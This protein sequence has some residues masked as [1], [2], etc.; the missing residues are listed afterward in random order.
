MLQSGLW[1][2]SSGQSWLEDKYWVYRRCMFL[3]SRPHLVHLSTAFWIAPFLFLFFVCAC[4]AKDWVMTNFRLFP[5]RGTGFSYLMVA[6]CASAGKDLGN[7]TDPWTRATKTA[8]CIRPGP[9][10][11]YPSICMNRDGFPIFLFL[12]PSCPATIFLLFLALL[13]FR[14]LEIRRSCVPCSCDVLCAVPK[15]TRP[16]SPLPPCLPYP[17][18]FFPTSIPLGKKN[19]LGFT[20]KALTGRRRGRRRHRAR[21]TQIKKEPTKKVEKDE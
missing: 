17:L 18:R 1:I 13:F 14:G 3:T 21:R 4:A 2:L 15:V 8:D 20:L 5:G 10:I 7:V 11:C 12:C 6:F 9:A 19:S 16:L